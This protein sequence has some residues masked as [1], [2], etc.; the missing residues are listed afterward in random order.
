M[1]SGPV[2]R[3]KRPNTW[4]HRPMLQ[5]G[6][7]LLPT[8]SRPHMADT[9]NEQR[10]RLVELLANP[11]IVGQPPFARFHHQGGRELVA[12]LRQAAAQSV[13]IKSGSLG[14][15][16]GVLRG[17][18]ARRAGEVGGRCAFARNSL[19]VSALGRRSRLSVILTID[20]HQSA[21]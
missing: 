4:L 1:A 14:A 9:A 10:H 6:K 12:Q 16:S 8:R 13:T 7:K 21:A 11:V 17:C 2:N 15:R 3:I 19:V 5:N 18:R 20:Q